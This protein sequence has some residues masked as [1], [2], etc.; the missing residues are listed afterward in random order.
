MAG[1]VTFIHGIGNQAEPERMLRGWKRALAD[2][3]DG[4]DLD[5][6]GVTSSLIYWADVMYE[7]NTD[8]SKDQESMIFEGV[9][10]NDVP[11]ID[12]SYLEAADEKE[13]AFIEAFTETYHL[14][15]DESTPVPD[16]SDVNVEAAYLLEA[17]PLPWALK[18]P[19]MKILLRDVHHY[20]FNFEHTPRPG[21][22]YLV[23]DEIRERF[24]DSLASVNSR[25]HVVIAHSMGTVI[26][27]D[28][29]KRVSGSGPVDT[30][31]TLGSPLGLSEIQDQMKPEYSSDDGFPEEL[32]SWYN[33]SDRLDPVCGV[34][35]K[36]ANDYKRGGRDEVR[37]LI[38]KNN[39]WFRHPVTKYLRQPTLQEA[40]RSALSV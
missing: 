5:V 10:E 1:H 9:S 31:I 21:D 15:A 33:F 16:I 35:P 32:G 8:A 2:G 30:V 18:K 17:I 39:G 37:D 22:N 19:L 13:R 24:L 12:E 25:P 6:F 4:V 7:A 38:V 28:V 3:G 27:Y 36:I 26:T 20:L 11:E 14:D 40:V 23:Q 34:D 29:L